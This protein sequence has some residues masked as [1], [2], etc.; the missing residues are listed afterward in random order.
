MLYAKVSR[1]YFTSG[2]LC[3]RLTEPDRMVRSLA[4]GFIHT[5]AQ[6]AQ[7]HAALG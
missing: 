3:D 2:E 5:A 6:A 7:R 4:L 1:F